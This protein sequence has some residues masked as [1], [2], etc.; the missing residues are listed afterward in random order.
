[1]RRTDSGNSPGHD[2]GALGDKL[3]EQFDVL[4]IDGIDAFHTELTNLLAPV[5]LF[6]NG[7]FDL[8]SLPGFSAYCSSM[9]CSGA[10]RFAEFV[11]RRNARFCRCALIFS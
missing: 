9:D 1:M 6:L 11:L 3:R 8:L 2:L 10:W 7:Q 4:V 5:I